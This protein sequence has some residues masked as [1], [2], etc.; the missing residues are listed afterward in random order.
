MA[1]IRCGLSKDG[2]LILSTV[3]FEK[4]DRIH[5]KANQPVH[6]NKDRAERIGVQAPIPM[7][8][9]N[10]HEEKAGIQINIEDAAVLYNPPPGPPGQPPI[11][12]VVTETRA[13]AAGGVE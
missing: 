7:I 12:I 4:G 1:V 5:F 6:V 10:V 13:G 11:T 9:I 2:K 3:E 8:D